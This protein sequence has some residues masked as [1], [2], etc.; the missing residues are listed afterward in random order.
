[1][2]VSGQGTC[3]ADNELAADP[4]CCVGYGNCGSFDGTVLDEPLRNNEGRVSGFLG[5]L[6]QQVICLDGIE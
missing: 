6:P 5:E 2:K 4:S 1:M 3:A